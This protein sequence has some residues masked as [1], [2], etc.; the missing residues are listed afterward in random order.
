MT[1]AEETKKHDHGRP[2]VVRAILGRCD[3]GRHGSKYPELVPRKL[4]DK[5]N[6]P[7]KR[8]WQSGIADL[9]CHPLLESAVCFRQASARRKVILRADVLIARFMRRTDHECNSASCSQLHL[10]NDDLFSAHFLLRKMQEDEW[11]PSPF[12]HVG[13]SP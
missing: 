9:G 6:E 13:S 12:L 10:M 5:Y 4:N 11:G 8:E 1:E 7:Y 3:D 2:A